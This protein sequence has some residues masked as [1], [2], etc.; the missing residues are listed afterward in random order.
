MHKRRGDKPPPREQCDRPED[1]ELVRKAGLRA[2][3]GIEAVRSLDQARKVLAGQIC[4]PSV[5]KRLN[6]DEK[7]RLRGLGQLQER[8]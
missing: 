7:E 1:R 5:A 2:I 8:T 4:T 3:C 6:P